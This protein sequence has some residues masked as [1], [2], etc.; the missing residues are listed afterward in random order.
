[1]SELIGD[2]ERYL[3][4]CRFC[5][6]CKP[7]AEVAGVTMMESH[8]TRARAMMLW[9]IA[10]GHAEWRSRDVELLYQSTLDS[11]SQAWCVNH[12]PVSAYHLA[13][14]RE[15][16][17]KG[18]AP[19]PVRQALARSSKKIAAAATVPRGATVL[20]GGEAAELGDAAAAEPARALLASLGVD[21][22][23]VVASTGALAYTLGDEERA[24]GEL[25][26]LA[27]ALRGAGLLIAD[28]P[29]TLLALRVLAGELL[30]SPFEA[31]VASL[32]ELL[33]GRA[34]AL[35]AALPRDAPVFVH[36]SRAAAALAEALADDQAIQP[37]FRGPEETLGRGRVYEAP[38]ELL[39]ALGLRRTFSLWSRSLARSCGSDDGLW[40]T[41]PRLAEALARRRLAEARAGG[42]EVLVTDSLLAARWM[43]RFCGEAEEKTA[44]R[45]LPE[46]V[47]R[48]DAR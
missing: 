45:W 8:T 7:A 17:A 11:I 5:P 34:G 35:E 40:L 15:V 23:A 47:R 37:G 31:K 10:H 14:R 25:A 9:R 13:A 48:A 12:F 36:D 22:L 24:R 6:M 16:V 2:Y 19:E 4:G 43:G 30:G 27:A 29:E 21:A 3:Q 42:A 28:G 26:G 39:D 44:V 32:S 33:A 18:L 1:M 38:R 41:Y 20:V 46:I